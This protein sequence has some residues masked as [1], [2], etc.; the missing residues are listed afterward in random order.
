M[1]QLLYTIMVF[2]L[3]LLTAC[4]GSSSDKPK[5]PANPSEMT[6]DYDLQSDA[7]VIDSS[8][9]TA[10][11]SSS[12]NAFVFD[13][14]Q[15]ASQG[16]NLELGQVLLLEDTALVKVVSLTEEGG[17][18]IVSTKPAA[19]NEF[20]E[21][22]DIN[23]VQGLNISAA[24]PPTLRVGK[25]ELEP[26]FIS[27]LGDSI[28][29]KTKVNGFD[30]SL[31]L[32]PDLAGQNLKLKVIVENKPGG[33]ETSFKVAGTGVVG[34]KQQ[35]LSASIQGGESQ[36][37]DFNLDDIS[38]EFEVAYAGAEAGFAEFEL[39][40]PEALELSIPIATP[41]PLGLELSFS[42][43]LLA[44]VELPASAS[45][46]VSMRYSYSGNAGFE[47][48]TANVNPKGTTGSQ[49]LEIN[50][51]EA[52]GAAGP[53]GATFAVS[54]PRIKLKTKL[55]PDSSVKI[56]NIY[57]ISSLMTG[58]ALAGVCLGAGTQHSVE[59]SYELSFWGFSYKGSHTFYKSYEEK[60]RGN[61][62]GCEEAS[63]V[64]TMA[65]ESDLYAN[66]TNLA[67]VLALQP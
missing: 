58:S 2:V 42:F 38:Y 35:R 40:L 23:L 64:A 63:L 22:A 49:S 66:V 48:G 65:S 10:L 46:R 33:G 20:F 14:A 51:A 31:E 8:Q 15:L 41:V 61:Q 18:L 43:A 16:L 11:K 50:E 54:A 13:K 9:M 30:L 28:A 12:E 67:R 4:G 27:T 24:N 57:S 26:S 62:K 21:N 47:T 17:D 29:Y 56:D 25:Q 60:R 1:K 36:D 45:T 55:S 34:L 44:K 53:V 7:I 5:N 3:L 32:E 19:L 52:A 59:G 39:A 6:F 37:F